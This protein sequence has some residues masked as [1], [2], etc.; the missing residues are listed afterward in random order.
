MLVMTE[1]Y[2][3]H[4]QIKSPQPFFLK[5]RNLKLTVTDNRI[6]HVTTSLGCFIS[7]LLNKI[8]GDIERKVHEHIYHN[9]DIQTLLKVMEDQLTDPFSWHGAQ[10]FLIKGFPLIEL[11]RIL[12]WWVSVRD[13]WDGINERRDLGK[14]DGVDKNVLKFLFIWGS[15]SKNSRP[16]RLRNKDVISTKFKCVTT[17]V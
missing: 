4:F 3:Y 14:F 12:T 13:T 8:A 5:S 9:N 6:R 15:N 16:G 7:Y 11:Q 10:H 1:G 2:G 17:T